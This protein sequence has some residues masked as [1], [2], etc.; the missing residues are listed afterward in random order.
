[1]RFAFVASE[2][3]STFECRIDGGDFDACESP[4]RSRLARGRHRFA[5]RATDKAGN[6]DPTPAKLTIRVRR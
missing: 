5:V 2:P 1:M 4:L 6:T 3:G